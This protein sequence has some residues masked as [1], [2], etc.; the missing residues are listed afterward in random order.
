[1]SAAFASGANLTHDMTMLKGNIAEAKTRF[2]RHVD[3]VE[4]GETMVLCPRNVPIAGIRPIPRARAALR[5]VGID[6]GMVVPPSFF[7][8]LPEELL[9]ACEEDHETA[10]RWDIRT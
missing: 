7:E 6:R 4:R 10:S 8:P 9:P 1:M 5:P 2:S 3:R